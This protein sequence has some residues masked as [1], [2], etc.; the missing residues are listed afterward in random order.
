MEKVKTVNSALKRV[1]W[2]LIAAL[3]FDQFAYAGVDLK[4]AELSFFSAPK[5]ELRLPESVAVVEDVWKADGGEWRVEPHPPSTIHRP[6]SWFTS[7]KMR[8][9]MNPATG[10]RQ[11]RW[12]T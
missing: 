10:T 2:L 3:S 8:T 4:P 5:F 11:R 7:S 6:P 1:S 12:N 9:R